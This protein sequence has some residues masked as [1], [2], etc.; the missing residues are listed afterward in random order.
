MG[1]HALI[2]E[3][4]FAE[5]AIFFNHCPLHLNAFAGAHVGQ[6]AIIEGFRAFMAEFLVL[7][8]CVTNILTDGYHVAASYSVRLRHVG[9]GRSGRLGGMAHVRIDDDLKI[10]RVENY[11]DTASLA[12]IGDML[13]LFAARSEA[14]DRL[15][16]RSKSDT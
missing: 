16:R 1:P 9:T 10:K 15:A 14:M 3:E 11:F 8:P 2:V 6:A 4:H 5:D 12:E 13:E 7:D